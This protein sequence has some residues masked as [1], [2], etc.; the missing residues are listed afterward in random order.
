SSCAATAPR[1]ATSGCCAPSTSPSTASLPGYATAA[2]SGTEPE[3]FLLDELVEP[4][5]R[6]VSRGRRLRLLYRAAG[7]GIDHAG[8]LVLMAVDAQQLPVGAVRRIVVVI[9]VLV[10][11]GQ[12]AQ[13]LAGKLP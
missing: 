4:G 8:V 6:P 13:P 2:S 5:E 10:M 1:A 3:L 12:L 11:H 7:L 9:A